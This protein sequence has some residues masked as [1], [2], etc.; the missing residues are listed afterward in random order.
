MNPRSALRRRRASLAGAACALALAACA[1]DYDW[2]EIRPSGAGCLVMLPGKPASMS[3]P[4]NLDGL[5]V[6]MAMSG[7]RV[8]DQSFT[9]GAV[10][11]PDAEPATRDKARAAMRAAMVR[12][13]AGRETAVSDATVPVL[14]LAGRTTATQAGVRVEASGRIGERPA[15]LS[16]LFVA[17]GN[18]AWQAVVIGPAADAEHASAFLDSFRILE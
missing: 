9:V 15:H 1:P 16:A 11:L 17:R 3:R 5:A 14:D 10:V 12:N 2:R 4:I 8:D 7:A 18:R 13:V 6:T